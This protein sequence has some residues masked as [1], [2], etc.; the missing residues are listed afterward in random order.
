LEGGRREKERERERERERDQERICYLY[1]Q[2]IFIRERRPERDPQHQSNTRRGARAASLTG[3]VL[4][5]P[6]VGK[7][8]WRGMGIRKMTAKGEG[9]GAGHYW[10]GHWAGQPAIRAV[11]LWLFYQR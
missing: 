1:K 5:H 4:K 10:E 9:E 8:G 11:F 7:G 6:V 2:Q 3:W